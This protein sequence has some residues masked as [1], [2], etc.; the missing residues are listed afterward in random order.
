MTD[1][2]SKEKLIADFNVVVA[3]AEELLK[4]TAGQ[5]SG[6]V[7]ELRGRVQ[8]RLAQAKASLVDAQEAVVAKAKAVGHATDDYVHDNPWKSVGIAAGIGLVVG[9]LIGRR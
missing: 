9:L 4:A 5:A 7:E 3:D 6:K 1:T 8:D 2:V